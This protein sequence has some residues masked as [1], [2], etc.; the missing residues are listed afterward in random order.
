[1]AFMGDYWDDQTMPNIVSLLKEYKDLFSQRFTNLKGIQGDLGG[2][3]ITLKHVVKPI[4][5]VLITTTLA[6]KKR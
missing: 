5:M 4:N 2:M 3:N 6:F 1:M